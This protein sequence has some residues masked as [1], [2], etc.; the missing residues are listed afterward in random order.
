MN[1]FY[2]YVKYVRHFGL[3]ILEDIVK[4]RWNE[5]SGEE[6]LFIKV[7]N[8]ILLYCCTILFVEYQ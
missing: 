5:M 2:F 8:L 1:N 4:A 3:K 6:K 7:G